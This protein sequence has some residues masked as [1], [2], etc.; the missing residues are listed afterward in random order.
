VALL[1]LL[2]PLAV[3]QRRLP[4]PHEW[5]QALA[6]TPGDSFEEAAV[7]AERAVARDPESPFMLLVASAFYGRWGEAELQR[8]YLEYLLR[9][10]DLEP[11]TVDLA[12][13]R[14]ASSY[15]AQR[16]LDEA[17]AELLEALAVGVDD[18][19]WHG[20][21]HYPLGLGPI[22]ACGLKLRLAD[23]EIRR[24]ASFLARELMDSVR[25]D[26]PASRRFLSELASLE[27]RLS[28]LERVQRSPRPAHELV[29]S[30]G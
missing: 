14:L 29:A 6:L 2:L 16:R 5:Y 1:L 21:P 30:P 15:S 13:E 8:E 24:G 4:P 17:R 22:R 19:E 12:H 7:W 11:D 10:P 28:P 25:A 27:K 26:C 9:L 3:P 23:V 20:Y 18:A